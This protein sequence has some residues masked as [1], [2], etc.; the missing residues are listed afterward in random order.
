MDISI[1]TVINRTSKVQLG[2][3][4]MTILA[5]PTKSTQ[6]SRSSKHQMNSFQIN[7]G[8]SHFFLLQISLKLPTVQSGF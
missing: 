4:G 6:K 1:I 7:I 3:N 5:K 8:S 2:C